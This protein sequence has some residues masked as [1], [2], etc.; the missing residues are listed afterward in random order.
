MSK[1]TNETSELLQLV[2]FS[3]GKEE[4]AIDILKVQEIIR[5]AQITSIPNAPS[6]VEGIIN[7]R[8][9]VIPVVS[10]RERLGLAKR[11]SDK[12]T[13][14]IVVELNG[15]VTGFLVDGVNEVLRIP[16]GIIEAPPEI[17]SGVNSKYITSI[18]KL[19]DRLIILLDLDKVLLVEE[20]D[21]IN[22][23]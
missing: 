21:E 2:S 12:D 14:I 10:L 3:V 8:G 9:R 17:T 23:I 19:E 18:A 16:S 13:R 4:F 22:K 20:L 5:M 15:K 1:E 6:F 11:Q 7:L